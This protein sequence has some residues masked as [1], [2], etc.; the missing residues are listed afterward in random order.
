M[1]G[2]VEE[3]ED[4]KAIRR[5][6]EMHRLVQESRQDHY[7]DGDSFRRDFEAVANAALDWD[8]ATPSE[9]LRA[10]RVLVKRFGR[11][12]A[13]TLTLLAAPKSM[14]DWTLSIRRRKHSEKLDGG[15][16]DR[17]FEREFLAQRIGKEV[18]ERMAAGQSKSD[19][20]EAVKKDYRT[21]ASYS[22]IGN[23]PA[24][25]RPKL[26][27]PDLDGIEKL[28]AIFRR[29]ARKRGY[30]DP[31]APHSLVDPREPDLR[32]SDIPKR[33]RPRKR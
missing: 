33:G 3:S 1:K 19:A 11:L 13:F 28:L 6:R 30:V 17:E 10:L 22:Q 7:P 32:L 4:L 31:Y 15:K 9:R 5:D 20:I 2:K 14:Q 8:A 24:F 26:D 18:Y 12:D 21:G 16:R 23:F 25:N 27:L 29:N